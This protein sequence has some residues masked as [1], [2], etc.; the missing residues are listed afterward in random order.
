MKTLEYSVV[1]AFTSQPFQGNPAAVVLGGDAL[2][3]A[4]MQRIAAEFNLSETVF[5]LPRSDGDAGRGVRLRWFTPQCEVSFCGHATLAAVHAWCDAKQCL[6]LY[7]HPHYGV[8][9]D[10]HHQPLYMDLP[11]A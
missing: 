9:D 7:H 1:D 4:A 3:D 10:R 11:H 2:T 6:L 5:V 8:R